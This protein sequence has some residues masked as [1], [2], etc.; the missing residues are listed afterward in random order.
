MIRKFLKKVFNKLT[1][2]NYRDQLLYEQKVTRTVIHHLYEQLFLENPVLVVRQVKMFLPLFYVDHIQKIIFQSREF[3]EIKTLAFLQL[4]F[5]QFHHVVDIGS[6]IGNHMLYY[7]SHLSAKTVICF[8]PNTFNRNTLT[9]NV[10][11]NYLEKIVTVYPFAVGAENGKGVQSEFSLGN[12]GMNRVDKLNTEPIGTSDIIEIRSLDSFNL[13][14]ID[15]IKIDVEGFEADVLQGAS[16]TILRCKPVLMIEVFENSR[17]QIDSLM[18][19]YGYKKLIT[20]EDYNSIYV[21]A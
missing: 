16:A 21:S 2:K 7:C 12:T 10:S 6:N 15:F 13:Q 19:G 8:E 3:Y 11:L 17:Q 5:K 9:K 18:T 4:H 20:L 1:V 14:Q